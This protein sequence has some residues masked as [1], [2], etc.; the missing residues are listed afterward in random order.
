MRKL[1]LLFAV[2]LVAL[3]GCARHYVMTLNNGAQIDTRGKPKLKGS[4]FV[5][6]DAAGRESSVPAGRVREIE[7]ASMADQNKQPFMPTTGKP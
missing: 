4:A 1:V 7:P 3:C 2:G 6:K 5:F